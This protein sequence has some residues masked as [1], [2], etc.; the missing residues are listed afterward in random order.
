MESSTSCPPVALPAVR[1]RPVVGLPRRLDADRATAAVAGQPPVYS[2][3]I[4]RLLFLV[5]VG[6]AAAL[7]AGGARE[8]AV[9]AGDALDLALGGEPLV[10]ALDPE[11]PGEI[12]PRGE[13][14]GPALDAVG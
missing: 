12:G 9:D 10:E 2:S 8:V 5:V 3:S 13:P 4:P 6:L 7:D 11:L 14:A 1:I